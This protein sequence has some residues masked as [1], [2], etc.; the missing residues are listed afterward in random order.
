MKCPNCGEDATG[1]FCDY[2]GTKMPQQVEPSASWP[3]TT[4]EASTAKYE[5]AAGNYA[6]A[7]GASDKS[8]TIALVLAI[9]FGVLG[10]HRFYVGKVGTGVLY[11]FTLGLIGIGWIYDIVM[12]CLGRFSDNQERPLLSW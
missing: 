9:V 3:S 12:I 5:S 7:A 2:C 1:K 6:S 8:R 11:L 10:V 4:P